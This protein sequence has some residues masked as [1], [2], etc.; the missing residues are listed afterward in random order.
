M[1]IYCCHNDVIICVYMGAWV[2]L[3]ILKFLL[4]YQMNGPLK[5]VR[6]HSRW[7]LADDRFA[8]LCLEGVFI[9]EYLRRK[10]RSCIR[11]CSIYLTS[12]HS[13]LK[14]PGRQNMTKYYYKSTNCVN[15]H[16]RTKANVYLKLRIA[17]CSSPR[18]LW[19][20]AFDEFSTCIFLHW[21]NMHWNTELC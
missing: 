21:S 3:K 12:G 2:G 15:K 13:T 6:A 4:T 1:P 9:L 11:S 18:L 8:K 7:S 19:Y 16:I 5:T 20:Q 17:A 10:P 14:T